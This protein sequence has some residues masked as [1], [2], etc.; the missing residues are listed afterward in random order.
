M[1]RLLP[2]L[3]IAALPALAQTNL[4]WQQVGGSLG[5]VPTSKGI[6]GQGYDTP[7]M[8]GGEVQ[9]QGGFLAHRL[10]INHAPFLVSGLADLDENTGFMPVKIPLAS[11]FAD[12]DGESLRYSVTLDGKATTATISHDTLTL[13]GAGG[14]SGTVSIVLNAQD[15][16]RSVADTFNVVVRPSVGIHTAPR[17]STSK[18]L[19]ARVP[20]I[21]ASTV[22]GLGD[23]T[24]KNSA[25]KET[26][27]CLSLELLLPG[28]ASVSLSIFDQIGTPVIALDQN[29]T[30]GDLAALAP[31]GD[32][33]FLYPVT[34]NLRAGNGQPVAAGVYLWKIK[35]RTTTGQVLETIHRMGVRGR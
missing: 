29:V 14:F 19:N 15:E 8:A 35:V 16:S 10:M 24:L 23:G 28:A 6:A 31:S 20:K 18:F 9:V 3:A 30:K 1:R 2:L 33:R 25:C 22:T 26:E 17:Q 32:G 27:D 11:H 7:L 21:F 5:V 34:W 12:L 13:S 4:D